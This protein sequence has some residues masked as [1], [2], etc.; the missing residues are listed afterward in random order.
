M[1]RSR[2]S[3]VISAVALAG[4]LG[5]AG[6]AAAARGGG[7]APKLEDNSASTTASTTANA[8]DDTTAGTAARVTTATQPEHARPEPGDNNGVDPVGHDANGGHSNDGPSISLPADTTSSSL[9][10]DHG[11]D[12]AGHDANDDHGNDHA[13]TSLPDQTTSAPTGAAIPNGVQTFTVAG[14]TVTVDVENGALSL[15]SATPNAGFAI[16]K[17]EVQSDR[18]EVEFRSND[19]DSRVRV[20]IDGGRLRVETGDN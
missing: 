12:P 16:D 9:P 3:I 14:G 4:V 1:H 19:T 6:V 5:M 10:D 15:A 11:A 8:V 2:R 13:S 7:S 17:S 20:R 18:V